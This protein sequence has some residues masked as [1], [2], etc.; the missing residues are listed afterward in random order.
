ML[1]RNQKSERKMTTNNHTHNNDIV[2]GRDLR[3]A[4]YTLPNTSHIQKTL[5]KKC[6]S[7][8]KPFFIR[9]QY[10]SMNI[11]KILHH[12]LCQQKLNTNRPKDSSLSLI[13]TTLQGF[14][15]L[16]CLSYSSILNLTF[17]LQINNG[18]THIFISAVD[19]SHTRHLKSLQANNC[20]VSI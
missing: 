1:L 14:L 8:V 2:F 17:L 18:F 3:G 4:W 6:P 19:N 12:N 10:A 13:N 16:C 5:L 11:T 20:I 15:I 9:S 7:L